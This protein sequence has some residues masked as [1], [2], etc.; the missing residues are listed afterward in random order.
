MIKRQAEDLEIQKRQ[1]ELLEFEIA[2]GINVQEKTPAKPVQIS[3][4]QS[5]ILTKIG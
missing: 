2:M 5:Y 4:S 3:V 1:L